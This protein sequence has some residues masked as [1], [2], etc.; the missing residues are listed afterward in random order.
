[1]SQLSCGYML[2]MVAMAKATRA[3]WQP[4]VN[5]DLA[6]QLDAV[7]LAAMCGHGL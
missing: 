6:G 3:Q 2:R 4:L 7:A 5:N 1:M